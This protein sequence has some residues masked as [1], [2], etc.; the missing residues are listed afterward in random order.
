M[1]Q[2]SR[3]LLGGQHFVIGKHILAYADIGISIQRVLGVF[4]AGMGT[5][6]A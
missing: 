6:I 2:R 5:S 3:L 1:F 4:A